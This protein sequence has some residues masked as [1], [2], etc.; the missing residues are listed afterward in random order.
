MKPSIPFHKLVFSRSRQRARALIPGLGVVAFLGC[1]TPAE[2][3]APADESRSH[4]I[5]DRA[6][7][8]ALTAAL[9][10]RDFTVQDGSFEFLDLSTCC[11]TTCSGNNPSSPYA[12]FFIPPAPS[13]SAANPSA[14]AD[15]TSSSYR[16]RADEA[17]VYVG[18]T[19]P[20]AAYYGFT[21]YLMERS[22]ASGARKPIF[23]SLSDTLN[24]LVV[25]TEGGTP[26]EQRTAI[27]VAA[28][29]VT[30]KRARAA[31]VEAG[32]ADSAI[33][34]LTLDPAKGR[35]GLDADA[36]AFGVLFR[37]ALVVDDAKREAYLANPG[38]TVLRITPNAPRPSAPL[39]SPPK[40][41]KASS[42]SE[43]VLTSSV[44]RLSQAI[45]AAYPDYTAR[46][47]TVD[48]GVPD[49]ESCIQNLT[50][51]GGDNPDTNY[52]GTAPRVL[53]SS[54]DEFYIAF[55]V[56]HAAT[57]KT[58]Y[59]NV[60]VYAL[61]KLVG[62]VGVASDQYADSARR[63][64]PQDPALPVLYAWK[65]A[66]ACNGEPYCLEVP[67]GACPTGIENGA[68]GTLNFRTYLEPSSKTAPLIDTLVRD[69]I[70]SFKRR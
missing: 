45:I 1:A 23:A 54:D 35:F 58:V 34:V 47:V 31:L 36:D 61:Q 30:A 66:R 70:L 6:L 55:G 65:I 18:A 13:Q 7:S 56:N 16:L 27:V 5:D 4:A 48:E 63:Y 2:P 68:L 9:T 67:K 33:N 10:A 46:A 60:S 50:F 37:M 49:P 40:R 12:A 20:E 64:L 42:P 51:C 57:Q 11:Q 69:R 41:P 53:F 22:D 39:P 14:R 44:N 32:V 59:S 38:G 52:P 26:F 15:G 29:N 8:E 62:L 3:A 21:P 25:R 17:I 43:S 19:A 24:H 28:D